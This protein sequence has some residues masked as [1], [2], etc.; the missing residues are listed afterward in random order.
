MRRELSMAGLPA[1][2]G[3]LY[4]VVP[5]VCRALRGG[6]AVCVAVPATVLQ[7]GGCAGRPGS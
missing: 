7:V 4:A 1:A 3:A 5:V 6:P 2:L